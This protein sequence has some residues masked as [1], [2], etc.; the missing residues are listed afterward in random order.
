MVQYHKRAK[1][2]TSGSG[3]RK[4]AARDKRLCHKGGFFARTKKAET[5]KEKRKSFRTRGG[6]LK[7]AADVV[8]W[9]NVSDGAAVKKSRIKNVAECPAN[10]HYAREN[11]MT[12]GTI[13]ETEL[14]RA[15][16]TS[17]PGQSGMVNAVLL[18]D[19]EAKETKGKK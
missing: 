19:K 9:A 14:G 17:R 1:T 6:R 16:I 8:A 5:D 15:R 11:I 13:I 7:V 2:K 12:K 18:K 3:A 10:R 4:R